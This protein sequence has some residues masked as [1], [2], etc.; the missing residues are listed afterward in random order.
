MVGCLPRNEHIMVGY[1]ETRLPHVPSKMVIW[2]H[3]ESC[4]IEDNLLPHP[5]IEP[6][7]RGY[8]KKTDGDSSSH[9]YQDFTVAVVDTFFCIL[10]ISSSQVF[11]V[12]MTSKIYH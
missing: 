12:V 4:S 8:T 3:M 1:V 10:S 11:N 2:K 9:M 6:Y 7:L 5:S